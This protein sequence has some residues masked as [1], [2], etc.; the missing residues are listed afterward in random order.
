[1]SMYNATVHVSTVFLRVRAVAHNVQLINTQLRRCRLCMVDQST[2]MFLAF[3][4][5]ELL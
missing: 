2:C 4:P 3:G 5:N 1:M